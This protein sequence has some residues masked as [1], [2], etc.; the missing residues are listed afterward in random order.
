MRYSPLKRTRTGRR[1]ITRRKM[2]DQINQEALKDLRLSD[3][4]MSALVRTYLAREE[5]R[6][7]LVWYELSH[8]RMIEPILRSNA[9]WEES[10][11]IQGPASLWRRQGRPQSLLL[12]CHL[13]CHRR[14]WVAG[15][16]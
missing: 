8:D 9:A 2:R 6:K 14:C 11:P 13:W 15:T 5:R 4:D 16:S 12:Y 1:L 7:E 10:L 3:A